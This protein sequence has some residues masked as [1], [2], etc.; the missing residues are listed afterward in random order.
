MDTTKIIKSLEENKETFI[1][2]LKGVSEEEIIWKRNPN[3]WCMLE[4]IC[5]LI[6]E[7]V[8][9]FR[10]RI[11]VQLDSPGKFPPAIDPVGWVL[12]R[13]Y[14]DQKFSE[15]LEQ[16][17]LERDKSIKWLQE[18]QNAN[19]D[20]FYTHPKLGNLSAGFFL[21]NWLAHDYLHIRQITKLKYDYLSQLSES[22]YR[23]AGVWVAD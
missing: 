2:L 5:H 8:E 1:S 3:K 15:K 20:N 13:K 12:E 21:T 14:L 11:R 18:L 22:K 9:D 7:E 10:T 19:W 16:F 6:D 23:Y 4:I 17:V